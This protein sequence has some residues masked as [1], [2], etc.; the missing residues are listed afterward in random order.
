MLDE[1]NFMRLFGYLYS[2]VKYFSETTSLE[3]VDLINKGGEVG[4]LFGEFSAADGVEKIDFDVL[5]QVIA[6]T[7]NF[8]FKDIFD[9][10]YLQ[11]IEK[12]LEPKLRMCAEILGGMSRSNKID[13]EG[14]G[15]PKILLAYG[16]ALQILEG[17]KNISQLDYPTRNNRRALLRE[18]IE[19]SGREFRP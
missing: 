12:R 13:E 19:H 16:A 7:D 9:Q 1:D 17:L 2:E 14:N 5:K 3:T 11:D 18:D 6:F 8:I 10:N 15:S 4:R